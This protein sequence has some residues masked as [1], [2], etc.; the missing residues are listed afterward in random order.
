[1]SDTE[2][3]KPRKRKT[4]KRAPKLPKR[5]LAIR[6]AD[7]G[8]HERWKKGRDLLNIPHPWRGIFVGPPG[9]GKSTTVKNLIIRADPPFEEIICVHCDPEYTKEYDDVGCQMIG[10]IPAPQE[11]DGEVKTLVIIDDIAM[12]SMSKDQK[13]HLD[14]LFGFVST[15]KNISVAL[16]QQDPFNIPA[17]VRRCAN[18]YVIWKSPDIDSVA[19]MAR[20]TGLRKNDFDE[21]FTALNIEGRDSLWIDLTP[22]SPAPLRQN[23]YEIIDRVEKE[24]ERKKGQAEFRHHTEA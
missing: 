21:I 19:T 7:K 20:R 1:M 13:N 5:L 17:S 3:E 22:K 24:R 9:T 2:A 6:N 23:G 12:K 4:K 10:T 11:F 16:A 15:H 8:F 18:L 14:R